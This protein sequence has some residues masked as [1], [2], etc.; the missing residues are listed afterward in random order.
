[1]IPPQLVDLALRP[2]GRP[3][4]GTIV[5]R[6]PERVVELVP[7]FPI[8]GPNHACLVRCAPERVE[9]RRHC[10]LAL[11][12]GEP[13]GAGWAT[14]HDAGVFMNGGSVAPRF[15]GQGVYRTLLAARMDLARRLGLPGVA[16]TARP[17]TSLPILA[18]LG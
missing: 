10:F 9:P 5:D 13:A 7:N 2:W 3:Q 14:V 4:L 12:D 17:D 18:R 1:M 16:T 15:Q 6:T 11:V 8:P